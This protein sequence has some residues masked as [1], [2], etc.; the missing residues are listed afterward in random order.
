MALS[1]SPL[2]KTEISR[3]VAGFGFF[4]NDADGIGN[5]K[6]DKDVDFE[7]F[8]DGGVSVNDVLLAFVRPV[9]SAAEFLDVPKE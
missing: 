7:R 2:Q 4:R 3:A 6:D 1:A 8:D 9:E 5:A